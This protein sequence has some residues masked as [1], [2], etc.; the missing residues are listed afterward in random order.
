[1]HTSK[2]Y[3]RVVAL[4]AASLALAGAQ[5]ALAAVDYFLKIDGI[6][7]ESTAKGHEKEIEILS[8]SW[9]VSQNSVASTA[10]ATSR[11]CVS[12][13]SFT[14]MTDKSTPA[15]MLSAVMGMPIPK[16]VLKGRKGTD[17][18]VEY[19][20][21]ELKNVFVTSYNMG[22]AGGDSLPVDQFSLQ[23]ASM[24]V[25]YVQQKADGS[26]G[27]VTRATINGGC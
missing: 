23:F 9:G 24:S 15:L 14:K 18:P 19:L 20:T 27:D 1:M 2:W 3:P 26:P 11:P 4:F 6:E 10:R 13:I 7:G 8:W 21:F 17:K 22:G 5:G 25:E 12:D 16:A